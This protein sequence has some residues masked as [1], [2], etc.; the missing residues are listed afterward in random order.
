MYL[1]GGLNIPIPGTGSDIYDYENDGIGLE[2]V[3]GMTFIKRID[4]EFGYEQLPVKVK[5]GRKERSEDFGGF[6]LRARY[7]F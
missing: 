2:G 6:I 4:V 5:G 3:F 7:V 1:E